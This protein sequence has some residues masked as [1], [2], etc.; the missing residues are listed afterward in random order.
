MQEEQQTAVLSNLKI[1]PD[2]AQEFENLFRQLT[3]V[4]IETEPST[5]FYQLCRDP[6]TPG[7]YTV[8]EIYRNRQGLEEHQSNA[9]T[10]AAIQRIS[11]QMPPL[12]TGS[13]E[14]KAFDLLGDFVLKHGVTPK[15]AVVTIL[16]VAKRD[17]SEFETVA[18]SLA[19]NVLH[20]EKGTLMYQICKRSK[21]DL[22]AFIELYESNE[23]RK[24]HMNGEHF[25]AAYVQWQGQQTGPLWAGRPAVRRLE[26]VLPR[27]VADIN[28][29]L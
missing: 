16:P 18:S 1:I 7:A 3:K 23:S 17:A 12:F 14:Y 8:A 28:S 26:P 22:F 2:K 5:L 9:T 19:E 29:R 25:R 6:E 24:Q 11:R 4:V 27:P 20:N 21:E 13:P 10:S 15:V